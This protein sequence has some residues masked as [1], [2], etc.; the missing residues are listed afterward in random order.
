MSPHHNGG[1]RC[2]GHRSLVGGSDTVTRN[3]LTRRYHF[4][5]HRE[6][7]LA[8]HVVDV[9]ECRQSVRLRR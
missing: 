2:G 3:A 6:H 9:N 7:R 5:E 1:N 8:P 4:V